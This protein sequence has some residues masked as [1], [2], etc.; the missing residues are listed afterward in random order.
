[1]SIAGVLSFGV[2]GILAECVERVL[3]VVV[4]VCA[5]AV[6]GQ[7]VIHVAVFAVRARRDLGSLVT[8]R[9][10]GEVIDGDL[11]ALV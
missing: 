6:T 9:A 11:A 5:G 7:A 2:G 10:L 1:L 4:V 3:V 8:G